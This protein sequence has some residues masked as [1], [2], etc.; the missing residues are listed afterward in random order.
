M[1]MP[2]VEEALEAS[3]E[4]LPQSLLGQ[5]P[6]VA[7]LVVVPVAEASSVEPRSCA[8]AMLLVGSLHHVD[9]EALAWPPGDFPQLSEGLRPPLRMPLE[10]L[11]LEALLLKGS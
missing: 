2:L 8:D 3:V 10:A 6:A 5:T 11:E 1:T 4:G 9:W 7:A